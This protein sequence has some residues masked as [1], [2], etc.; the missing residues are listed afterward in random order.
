MR[1]HGSLLD[2]RDNEASL[3]ERLLRPRLSFQLLLLVDKLG[4]HEL[5]VT[6]LL[7]LFCQLL[8]LLLLLLAL[9]LL[10]DT[11]KDAGGAFSRIERYKLVECWLFEALLLEA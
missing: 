4:L 6:L 8:T 2:L 1:I 7:L 5:L 11:I 3:L 10:F 9:E